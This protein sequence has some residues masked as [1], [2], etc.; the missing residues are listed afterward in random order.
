[1]NESPGDE[2][3]PTARVVGEPL[4]PAGGVPDDGQ[5]RNWD[6]QTREEYLTMLQ[7]V[8]DDG[9][10][11][12]D[13]DHWMVEDDAIAEI[14]AEEVARRREGMSAYLEAGWAELEAEQPDHRA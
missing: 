3:V 13:H 8:H 10:V 2:R 12:I 11:Q 5:E 9:S 6:G 14:G 4:D 7:E 1:M